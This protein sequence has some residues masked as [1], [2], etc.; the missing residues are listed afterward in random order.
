MRDSALENSI[1]TQIER[2]GMPDNDGVYYCPKCLAPADEIAFDA[3]G[4]IVGCRECIE[5][6][7][8]WEVEI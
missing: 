6:K 7:N 5:W 8:A 2:D 1:I 4:E 3:D